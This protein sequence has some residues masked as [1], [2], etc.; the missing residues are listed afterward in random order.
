MTGCTA[1]VLLMFIKPTW[2]YNNTI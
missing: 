1:G 2:N